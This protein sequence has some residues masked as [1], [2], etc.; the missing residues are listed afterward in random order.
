MGHPGS[1]VPERGLEGCERV[2]GD[3]EGEGGV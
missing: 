1:K 2:R 3:C